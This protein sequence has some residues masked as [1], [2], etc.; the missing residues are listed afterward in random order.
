[1][2]FETLKIWY[3]LL[4]SSLFFILFL[5]FGIHLETVCVFKCTFHYYDSRYFIQTRTIVFGFRFFGQL[6]KY[7][8]DIHTSYFTRFMFLYRI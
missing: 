7:H 8:K 3:I 2:Q 4:L 6:N 1:M 5:V